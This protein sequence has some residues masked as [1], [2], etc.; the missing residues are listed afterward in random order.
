M[1]V[2][3]VKGHINLV[4]QDLYTMNAGGAANSLALKQQG[5]QFYFGESNDEQMQFA[6]HC[7]GKAIEYANGV[8]TMLKHVVAAYEGKLQRL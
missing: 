2:E 7:M 4:I 8:D 6:I 5:M 1:D 3:E